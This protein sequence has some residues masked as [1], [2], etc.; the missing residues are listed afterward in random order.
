MRIL[1]AMAAA[2]MASAKL[3]IAGIYP[4]KANYVSVSTTFDFLGCYDCKLNCISR[5][6]VMGVNMI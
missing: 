2:S 6:P 3:D 4:T 5:L 1:L